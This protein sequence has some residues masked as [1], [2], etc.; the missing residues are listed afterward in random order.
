MLLFVLVTVSAVG[1]AHFDSDTARSAQSDYRR[2][3]VK[4]KK[5]YLQA[6]EG[7]LNAAGKAK[8][9]EEVTTI[10]AE[11]QRIVTAPADRRRSANG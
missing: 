10:A 5:D 1:A 11:I 7:A 6:L 4:A 2:A 9:A 3:L 8:R